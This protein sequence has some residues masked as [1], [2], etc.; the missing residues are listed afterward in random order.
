MDT[1][2]K[3]ACLRCEY[4]QNPLGIDETRPRLSWIMESNRRGARQTAWQVRV[5]SSR[6]RLGQGNAD[7]WDSGRVE[8]DQSTHVVYNGI[9]LGSRMACHW[10]VTIWDELGNSVTSKVSGLVVF[11]AS[12]IPQIGVSLSQSFARTRHPDLPSCLSRSAPVAFHDPD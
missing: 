8:N 3:V 4:L 9:P 6:K 1:I 7:L 5:A 11:N 12:A 2:T 10:Y